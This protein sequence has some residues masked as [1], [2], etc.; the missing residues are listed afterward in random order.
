MDENATPEKVGQE[1]GIVVGAAP[2]PGQTSITAR[3]AA[4]LH[5]MMLQVS[6]TQVSVAKA[7]QNMAKAINVAFESDFL[8]DELEKVYKAARVRKGAVE[9]LHGDYIGLGEGVFAQVGK[10]FKSLQLTLRGPDPGSPEGKAF[11]EK[12]GRRPLR[13]M[14][15]LLGRKLDLLQEY[16]DKVPTYVQQM[17]DRLEAA[18]MITGWNRD[19]WEITTRDIGLDAILRPIARDASSQSKA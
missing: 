18:R 9:I 15:N 13:G 1:V 5:D 12:H 4:G 11:I 6:P 8:E 7:L 19:E 14:V 3:K 10:L 17:L 16:E 2:A